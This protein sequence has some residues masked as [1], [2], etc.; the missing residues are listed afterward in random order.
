ME[1]NQIDLSPESLKK[2]AKKIKLDEEL[3]ELTLNLE[4]LK[5]RAEIEGTDL[6]EE[7]NK[8]NKEIE[9]TKKDNEEYDSY[10][11]PLVE[12]FQNH[13][14]VEKKLKKLEEKRNQIQPGIYESLKS[15]YIQEKTSITAKIN[16]SI[17][18][19][20]KIERDASKAT[21]TLKYAIEELSVRK[22]I[23]EIPENE[24]NEQ[25]SNLKK[26]LS[27][28]DELNEAVKILL[29]LVEA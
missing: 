1:N 22:D 21:Q 16:E 8:F 25:I 3:K 29:E 9:K 18:Q 26:E 14:D 7:I 15:E 10:N 24:F 4:K 11:H 12:L 28:S 23:E 2:V 13:K 17:D 6:S 27:Q 19:L 5:V 20:K